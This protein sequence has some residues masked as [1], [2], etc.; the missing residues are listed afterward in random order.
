[1][2]DFLE[3]VNGGYQVLHYGCIVVLKKV[4]NFDDFQISDNYFNF[5]RIKFIRID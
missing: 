3:R 4:K 1:M 5:A 2:N